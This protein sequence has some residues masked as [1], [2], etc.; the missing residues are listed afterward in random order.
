M[1]PPTPVAPKPAPARGACRLR[2]SGPTC[3]AQSRPY[4]PLIPLLLLLCSGIP[5]K[6]QTTQ[7]YR[8]SLFAH[9]SQNR[10]WVASVEPL[11]DKGQFKTT[12]REQTLPAGDWTTL[13]T[14]LGAAAA[15]AQSQGELAVLLADDGG[16]KRLASGG[17]MS[18][19]PEVPGTNRVLAWGSA[20]PTL[21]AVRAVEG[22]K[23]ALAA[24]STA[25]E[26]ATRPQA[27]ATRPTIAPA[28]RPAT[29]ATTATTAATTPTTRPLTLVLFKY[30]RGDWTA[31]A[32]LPPAASVAAT[33]AISGPAN[34]PILAAYTDGPIR[35]WAL[36]D[37]R[38][39]P[40]GDVRPTTRPSI[41]GLATAANVP[42][43]W[44]VEPSGRMR[45][46]LRREGEDWKP[47]DKFAVPA[48]VPPAA[49]RTLAAAGDEFRAVFLHDGKWTEQR[50]DAAGVP[51][52][53]R[54]DLPT[55]P[56]NLADPRLRLL[57]QAFI[58]LGVVIVLLVTFYKRRAAAA[59][60]A[61]P[62][63]SKRDEE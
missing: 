30:E 51:R 32:D 50:Y 31:V 43:A 20:G 56:S 4:V 34:K 1:T 17:A 25:A 61:A 38:W 12:I 41:V 5:A 16:W 44:T 53:G 36:A 24:P 23:A 37:G 26:P 6:S 18:T 55:P 15:L 48:D 29:T 47:A 62:P 2:L 3:P 11:K 58:M 39:E 28:S 22:G 14:V 63:P 27:A 46:Y 45:L 54:A 40:A 59:A 21:Y 13:G 52:G 49:Q 7:P 8:P 9:G 42:A 19:G 33:L 35:T 60:G 57:Y 10:Y